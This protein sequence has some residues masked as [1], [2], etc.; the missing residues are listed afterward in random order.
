[1]LR[2]DVIDLINDRR[3]WAFAGSGTSV[4]AGGVRWGDLLEAC[5]GVLD[6]TERSSVEKQTRYQKALSQGN[7]PA[8]FS[9]VEEV[10]GRERLEAATRA[11]LSTTHRPGPLARL[12]GDWPFAGYVT[13]NYDALLETAISSTG[14]RGWAPVG[15]TEDEARKVSGDPERVIW[16]LHGSTDLPNEKSRLVLTEEDYDWLYRDESISARQLAALLA[17]HRFIFLGF[18]FT[19]FDIRQVLRRVGSLTTPARPLIAFLPKSETGDSSAEHRELLDR[20]NVDVIPYQPRNGSHDDL[21]NLLDVYRSFTVVRSFSY[22]SGPAPEAPSFDPETTG[23]LLYNEFALKPGVAIE[24]NVL[25]TLM[26]AWLMALLR[27]Q[28][29]TSR[30]EILGDLDHR[31][32]LLQGPGQGHG[33]AELLDRVAEALRRQG[34]VEI[35]HVRRDV[36]YSLT[37]VGADAVAT[38]AATAE[39]LREQFMASLADRARDVIQAHD[40]QAR[41]SVMAEAFLKEILETRAL[42]VA[43]ALYAPN[44]RARGYHIVGLLQT[45]PSYMQRLRSDDEAAALSRL[46]QGILGQPSDAERLYIGVAL[47]AQL[48][49]HLLGADPLTLKQRARELQDTVFVLDSTS[50]IPFLARSSVGYAG[51]RLLVRLIKESGA[52]AATTFLLALEV[53][54]HARWAIQYTGGQSIIVTP[55]LRAATGRGGA[56]FNAFLDGLL[57][58][59]TTGQSGPDLMEYIRVTCNSTAP[60]SCRNDDIVRTLDAEGIRCAGFEEFPGFAE[61]L[62]AEREELA[63]AIQDEREKRDTY[64]H[65]RQVQAEAEA[66]M[67]V[68]GLRDQ[69]RRV[70]DRATRSAYFV[71]HTRVIDAVA[72]PGMRITMRP[73]AVLQWISTVMPT[74]LEDLGAL[75]SSIQYELF[76]RGIE[77]ID[78]ERIA[79]AFS[80]LLNASREKLEQAIAQHGD[81]IAAAYGERADQAFRSASRL[82]IPIVLEAFFVQQSAALTARQEQLKREREAYERDRK[83]T[84][85]DRKKLERLSRRQ[86]ERHQKAIRKRRAAKSK[87]GKKRKR[88]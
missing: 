26:T 73:E 7:L 85:A 48:G 27:F 67:L 35:L 69:S 10:S 70:I 28:D 29:A 66:L 13:T 58:E 24:E 53:A 18:G 17:Q 20:F 68:R 19:E 84:D 42:G 86:E 56:R 51:A 77:I 11:A 37:R 75:V 1:M 76:D 41:V 78:R 62:L 31:I 60:S 33:A 36:N 59:I 40:A 65:E 4:D 6:E 64:R 47:Q 49:A 80:P 30:S 14:A 39:R 63:D 74:S 16:H 87:P 55:A 3:T 25:E 81:L 45:L 88:K 43:T 23:L 54:E 38:H 46:V 15:N 83:L 32:Q 12:V 34:L 71:S 22:G 72:G 57:A 52:V 8:C 21:L 44:R 50:L 2:T 9:V 61:E 82:D 79:I 5:I